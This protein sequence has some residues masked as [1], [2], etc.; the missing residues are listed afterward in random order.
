MSAILIRDLSHGLLLDSSAL[1]LPSLV[2]GFRSNGS[3]LD[4]RQGGT[5]YGM[6]W[7]GDARIEVDGVSK[8]VHAREYFS[9]PLR[10]RLTISG[11]ADGF[12]VLRLGYFGLGCIGG[13]V[14]ARG[15]LKYIDGCSDT[16][17]IAP[18]RRGDPCFNLL[19]MPP[20]IEQTKHTHPTLR[21]GLVHF[22]YG[23]C[24][25]EGGSE[26]MSPGRLFILPPDAAHRFSTVGTLGMTLTVFHPDSDFGPTDDEHPMLNRTVIEG[27]S[28]RHLEA[29]R[30]RELD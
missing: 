18:P 10:D 7:T 12:A 2:Y 26:D 8:T 15:R 20:G 21:V 30:T 23:R 16:L 4:I 6:V 28:A 29:I 27:I 25:T 13:P 9:M 24:Y 11:H 1:D 19:H 14:E 3:S 5:L 17:L 22:G